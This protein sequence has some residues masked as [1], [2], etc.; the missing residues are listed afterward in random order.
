MAPA[1]S[2]CDG[3]LRLPREARAGDVSGFSRWA[4]NTSRNTVGTSRAV[5]RHGSGGVQGQTCRF[6]LGHH[7]Q[8]G[9]GP[10]QPALLQTCPRPVRHP[11]STARSGDPRTLAKYLGKVSREGGARAP[12]KARRGACLQPRYMISM[13]H[14]PWGK[15]RPQCG[16]ALGRVEMQKELE[17]PSPSFDS[18]SVDSSLLQLSSLL[19]E[20]F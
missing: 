2:P 6:A 18:L 9:P 13:E 20:H 10:R 5:Q 16:F 1:R 11:A 17:K 19:P 8:A 4:R 3:L 14:F 7:L 12:G 15:Q